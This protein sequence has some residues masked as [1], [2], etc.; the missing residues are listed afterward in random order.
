MIAFSSTRDDCRNSTAPD[1][2]SSG[3]IGPFHAV[4]VMNADG[5]DQR[6]LTRTQGMLID[7]SPDGSY[8]VFDA[9][10]G[11]AVVRVDGSG[12]ALLAVGA[13]YPSFPD[14]TK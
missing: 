9:P 13:A 5:S 2:R 11:L 4:Y 7:W 14:W 3:D 6:P 10:S 1:C 12:L 8:L